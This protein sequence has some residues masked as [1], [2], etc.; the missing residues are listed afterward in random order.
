M[1]TKQPAVGLNKLLPGLHAAAV[2]ELSAGART[3]AP[4]P[5]TPAPAMG[6]L[7]FK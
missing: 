3:I 6:S 1:K 7:A 2:L 4:P 5:D